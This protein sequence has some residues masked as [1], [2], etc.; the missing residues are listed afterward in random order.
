VTD[1]SAMRPS[2]K[3]NRINFLIFIGSVVV[4]FSVYLATLAPSIY[5]GDGIELATVCATLG[6]AH[7]TGYPLFTLIGHIFCQIFNHNPA[8]GTNL[9]CALFGALAVGFFFLNL[10]LALQLLPANYFLHEHYRQAAALAGAFLIA[11]SRTFWFHATTTEVYALHIFFMALI[12][13]LFL[14]HIT[15]RR[16]GYLMGMMG[17]WGLAFSN[18]MLSLTLA[19]L[20]V[21]AIANHIAEKG[22]SKVLIIS[23]LLFA[24]G[25]SPYIYLPIRAAQSPALNWG[26]PLSLKNFIWVVSGGEFKKFQFM[27][28]L[29]GIPF[30]VETFK[31]HVSQRLYFFGKWIVSEFYEFPFF[32]KTLKLVCLCALMVVWAWGT[33]ILFRYKKS[34]GAAVLG[35]FVFSLLMSL[36]YNIPDIE[37]YFLAC[38]PLII[39]SALFGLIG[40]LHLFEIYFCGRKVNFIIY[41]LFILP[42]ISLLSLYHFEDKS[43]HLDAF[44]YGLNVCRKAP[45]QSLVITQSDNDIYVLW[46]MQKALGMR[47][48]L[49]IVGSNFI[50]SG[51]YAAYFKDALPNSPL[52]TIRQTD[53][54]ESKE[55]FINDL[56]AWIIQPNY[57]KFPIILT[58]TDAYL[59]L[60]Y[61]IRPFEKALDD[62]ALQRVPND[63]RPFLP[64]PY[65]YMIH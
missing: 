60:F 6:I 14:K 15:E 38:L 13:L 51:W 1:F 64:Q 42:L 53:V 11:F 43:R 20:I 7:P 22:K 5:W 17:L 63:Y 32:T 62:K 3:K 33:G 31:W 9:M 25:L 49:T 26:N 52:I 2:L 55:A 23:C 65:L 48:D 58:W 12:I 45:Y 44:N 36:L 56:M 57:K 39:I 34:V 16:E 47:D 37:P 4:S 19:P 18:H 40:L 50:H 59:E 54:P 28:F 8:L 30:T 35:A 61:D 10:N 27:S 41:P 46:Y 29:P 21:I 24:A